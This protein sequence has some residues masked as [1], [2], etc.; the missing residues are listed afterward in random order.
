MFRMWN[1]FKTSDKQVADKYLESNINSRSDCK[2]YV[3]PYDRNNLNV[4]NV[5]S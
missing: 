3:F 1:R 5:S 4:T 2:Y